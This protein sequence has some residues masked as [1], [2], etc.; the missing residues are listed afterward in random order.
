METQENKPTQQSKRWQ[1]VL[2]TP[3]PKNIVV[4]HPFVKGLKYIPIGT[5]EGMLD[6][7]FGIG[8]WSIKVNSIQLIANSVVVCV[9]LR[10]NFNDRVIEHDGVGASPLQV[11]AGANATD[12]SQLKSNAVML[13][14][15]AA[16]SFAIKDAAEHLGE[17]FGRNLNREH[18]IHSMKISEN[19]IQ[20]EVVRVEIN[21]NQNK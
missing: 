16:K 4:E 20:K 21:P 14:V 5:V 1:E 18:Y 10:I 8:N 3:P 2:A 7:I 15:P 6:R 11:N 19:K 9:T 12:I 17:M 13:A